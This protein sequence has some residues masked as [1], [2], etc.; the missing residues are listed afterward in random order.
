MIVTG[1]EDIAG[2]CKSLKHG[3][4]EDGLYTLQ[5]EYKRRGEEFPRTFRLER[6]NITTTSSVTTLD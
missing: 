3:S 6:T 5:N 1:N 2:A 4:G